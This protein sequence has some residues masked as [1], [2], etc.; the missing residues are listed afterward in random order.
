MKLIASSRQTREEL[1][2]SSAA[3]LPHWSHQVHAVIWIPP[4][5]SSNSY[6]S[7]PVSSSAPAGTKATTVCWAY[8]VSFRSVL[9]QASYHRIISGWPLLPHSLV[10]WCPV[11][12]PNDSFSSLE[13]LRKYSPLLLKSPW[14]I[15]SWI[16]LVYCLSWKTWVYTTSIYHIGHAQP[17]RKSMT[18]L[19]RLRVALECLVLSNAF[20]LGYDMPGNMD[21]YQCL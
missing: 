12:G 7:L 3:M 11:V 5:S 4:A 8:I 15:L 21:R 18:E 1:A 20:P 17:W 13:K 19:L 2:H 14:S 9:Q 6:P 10:R 16:D